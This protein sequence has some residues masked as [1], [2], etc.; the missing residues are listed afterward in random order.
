MLGKQKTR[1]KH[2]D[3][4]AAVRTNLSS[5]PRAIQKR[6][7]VMRGIAPVILPGVILRETFEMLKIAVAFDASTYFDRLDRSR[8]IGQHGYVLYGYGATRMRG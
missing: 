8:F 3:I 1:C 5:I 6:V 4:Y 7:R 2:P